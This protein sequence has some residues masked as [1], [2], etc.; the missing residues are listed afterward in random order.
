MNFTPM[1]KTA[2]NFKLRAS[3]AIS[4]TQRIQSKEKQIEVQFQD[5]GTLEDNGQLKGLLNMM[6]DSTVAESQKGNVREEGCYV[7]FDTATGL[8]DT[9]PQPPYE[10]KGV[11][12]TNTASVTLGARPADIYHNSSPTGTAVYVVGAFHTHTGAAYWPSNLAKPVGPSAK[13]EQWAENNKL[14]VLVYDYEADPKVITIPPEPAVG[15]EH[16]L[17]D[18]AMLYPIKSPKRRPTP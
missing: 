11:T 8:Y 10:G 5:I 3:A 13:D 7:L 4:E 17:T 14:P 9:W 18:P 1:A 15:G 2:G 12:G 6:W 16:D